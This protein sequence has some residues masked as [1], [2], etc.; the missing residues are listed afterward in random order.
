MTLA[1]DLEA[2]DP[3]E[4]S[5]SGVTSE[6]QNKNGFNVETHKKLIK[7]IIGGVIDGELRPMFS[8]VQFTWRKGEGPQFYTI[9]DPAIVKMK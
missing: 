2:E 5:F 1:S 6:V 9:D 7:D 8:Y 3:S 4:D